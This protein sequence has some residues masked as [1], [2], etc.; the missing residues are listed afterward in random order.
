MGEPRF[1]FPSQAL[2]SFKKKKGLGLIP[3]KKRFVFFWG[4]AL[5]FFKRK[6]LLGSPG[7]FGIFRWRFCERSERKGPPKPG[8]ITRFMP[9]FR[10]RFSEA[11]EKG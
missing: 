4:Q 6:G 7:V 2:F 9:L 5:F 3:K 11:S 10:Q 1:E 8:S